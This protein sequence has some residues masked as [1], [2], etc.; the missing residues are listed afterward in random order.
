MLPYKHYLCV[1]GGQSN[2]GGH[3]H[4]GYR[5]V[6]CEIFLYDLLKNE[7]SEVKPPEFNRIK[8]SRRNHC[9]GIFNQFL[10]VYGGVNT[11]V[12]YLDDLQVFNFETLTWTELSVGG[13]HRPPPLARSRMQ[14]AFHRQRAQQEIPDLANLPPLD[15]AK[16]D[17]HLAKEGFYMFGG[18][19]AKGD[20]VNDLWVL[21]PDKKSAFKWTDASRLTKG[22]PPDARFDHT[23]DRL[24]ELLVVL[25]GRSKTAFV[26]TVY[27]L[28]LETLVW[29]NIA[30]RSK[31]GHSRAVLRA[32][33]S[34]AVGRHDTK[35]YIFGGL[36]SAFKLSNELQ[37][38]KFDDLRK[39]AT[40]ATEAFGF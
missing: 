10:L 25:G 2:T 27:V 12:Q 8:A 5:P 31:P 29:T 18:Q 7:W 37:V 35:I 24:R 36:D 39:Q 15:W 38:L 32:E 40:A 23:M 21:E 6:Q 28:D 30:L 13:K 19:N 1:H 9:G 26:D 22:K 3:A 14:V 4:R 16:V 20:A 34:S 33:H 11:C 17:W